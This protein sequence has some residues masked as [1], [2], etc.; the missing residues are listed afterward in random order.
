[1]HQYIK[2][3]W[4][5]R[6]VIYSLFFK[7]IK[8]PSYMGR[9][10]FLMGIGKIS[11]GKRT[12][13]FPNARM[14]VHGK[15]ANIII[16]DNVGIGQNVHIISGGV[17]T[18]GTNTTI[19]PNVFINNIDNDYKEIDNPILDQKILYKETIIGRNCFIGIGSSIHAGTVLGVQCI[20]GS[21]SV[22]KGKFPD[23][24]VIAGNPAKIIK[25]YNKK[26]KT[27]DRV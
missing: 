2:I 8:H 10:I 19:A 12:R 9:P 11:L 22:V 20:V 7:K 18:I 16:E 1:M 26:T 23:Y 13:I 27:W 15:N 21:N 24:C 5:F 6:A 17:L 25:K 4:L 3:F 14:E